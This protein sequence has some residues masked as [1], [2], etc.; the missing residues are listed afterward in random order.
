MMLPRR[1]I[2]PYTPL[3]H[4]RYPRDKFPWRYQMTLCIA[5]VCQEQ[6]SE[7]IVIGTDWKAGTDIAAAENEDKLYWITDN[8]AVMIAGTITRAVDLKNTYSQYFSSLTEQP[9]KITAPNISDTLREPLTIY[10]EKRADEYTQSK[11]KLSYE[12]FLEAVGKKQIP[13][14][15]ATEIFSELGKL[16]LEAELII[17]LYTDDGAARVYRVDD[18]GLALCNNFVAI[19]SGS[20][21][22]EGALYQRKQESRMRVGTTLYNVYEAM[23]LGSISP[24]VGSEH[25]LSVLRRPR[26]GE[27]VMSGMVDPS[28]STNRLL[29]RTFK[30]YGPKP[31]RGMSLPKHAFE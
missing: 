27:T 2:I 13:K 10:L 21:I 15:V 4:K 3:K 28:E 22:A 16:E 17:C 24:T 23:K 29:A 25:T 30:N 7:R 8:I 18:S 14:A 1:K 11:I 6:R 26:K 9:P 31:M 12:K 5:A 20:T 19:G